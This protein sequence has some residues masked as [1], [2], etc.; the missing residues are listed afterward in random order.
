MHLGRAQLG[1]FSLG[2]KGARSARAALERDRA[3]YREIYGRARARAPRAGSPP[4]DHE[5]GRTPRAARAAARATA[6]AA[7]AATAATAAA[8]APAAAG[9]PVGADAGDSRAGSAAA[10]ALSR[11]GA[12]LRQ[13]RR[14]A[15][16]RHRRGRRRRRAEPTRRRHWRQRQQPHRRRSRDR[17]RRH[18]FQLSSDRSSTWL[19]EVSSS[20]RPRNRSPKR[21]RAQAL[22]TEASVGACARRCG[23]GA[24]GGWGGSGSGGGGARHRG[25]GGG[26]H[27]CR[28]T[29]AASRV[30]SVRGCRLQTYR[31]KYIG[32]SR[33][34]T[35]YT[36]KAVLGQTGALATS[37]PRIG[38][39]RYSSHRTP[40]ASTIG[41]AI[42]GYPSSC[43]RFFS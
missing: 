2:S 10:A 41:H 14:H 20:C 19:R 28:R 35:V 26:G 5:L 8:A 1:R 21:R 16:W 11:R 39:G 24:G 4:P 38:L 36:V 33:V 22:E 32:E 12:P 6:A 37:E 30:R 25:G 3:R 43:H 31:L 15:A 42:S 9:R 13:C 7:A 34:E 23:G 40:R 17:C 29:Q 27:A 18:L